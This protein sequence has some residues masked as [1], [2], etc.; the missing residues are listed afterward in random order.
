MKKCLLVLLAGL[1]GAALVPVVRAEVVLGDVFARQSTSLNGKWNVIVDPYD[2]G[3]FD[4]R[5]VPYDAAAKVTGGFGLDHHAKDATDLVEYNFDTSPTLNV[6]G[7]WNSQDDKL[8]Y[9]EGSVWYRKKFDVS[10]TDPEHR[11][12]IYFAAVN[13]EA[14]VY[15]NGKKLGKHIGGFTPFAY[16]VTKL[17]KAQGNSLVVR[18]NNNRHV[19]GVPTVNTDWW[20]YGGITRDVLLVE[21]PA[22]FISNFRTRLKPGTTNT[23]EASVQLDGQDRAQTVKVNFPSLKLAAEMKADKGGVAKFELT[24]SNLTLWSPE[25]P[26][27]HDV[28]ISAGADGLKDK[29]GFRTIATSGTDVLLN[30]KKV[31]LRGIC[32]HEENPLEGRRAWSEAD[33]RQL[34]GWA[35]ELGCNFVRLAHY[36]HNEH[37]ARVADEI[38]IMCWEE[39]PVYWTIAWTNAATAEN[40]QQQLRDEIARDQNRASVV[41]W[42]VANE[43][44][45]SK[46][47]TAFLKA[48]VDEA[49]AL[50][51]TRLISAAM[52]VRTETNAPLHKIVDDPFG[53]Y[54]DLCSFNQYTGWY[55]GLPEKIDRIHWTIKYNKPVFISEFGADAKQGMHADALTRFSEEYQADV[56]RR[57]LPMLDKIP[58]FTG[59][60]P[61][62]LVDFRS[63]RR[64]LPVVQDGWNLKGV[65]GHNGEKKMAFDVLKNFYDAKAKADLAR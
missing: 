52:E 23:I 35:K 40:A 49:R 38:G 11:L 50:D 4:Y 2:T 36:P 9:Y 57:T 24:P 6:P 53:Q 37:M 21:T 34:L 27:L 19:E 55:D 26:V 7:D 1:A 62:I 41:V 54:T 12:F 16:E 51:G 46:P 22:T 44:P 17:V 14:D 64:L 10:K 5:H 3:Y 61:W 15:L 18:V 43:T 48:L 33:A 30:G 13:Y 45:V 25:N 20:N 65:I 59:C 39:I 58:G 28:E 32:I 47:R 63:P 60:T 42:S 56:Y 8:F 29:V 31:F